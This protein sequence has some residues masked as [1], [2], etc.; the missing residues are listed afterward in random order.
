MF[1]LPKHFSRVLNKLLF[2]KNLSKIAQKCGTDKLEHG[3]I[4]HYKQY[5]ENLRHKE[6][7]I[8][9][10]GI[11]Q[12]A[13]L[14]MWKE[15]FPHSIIHAIDIR[16]KSNYESDRIRVYQGDQNDSEF[17]KRIAKEAGRFDII[18][19]DGSHVSKHI[20]TSF[21]TLFPF[22][23]P[24]GIYVIEDL[25]TAYWTA[26]GGEW[27]NLNSGHTSM[28]FIKN[29][30]DGL[31]CHWIPG[32]ESTDFDKQICAIHSYPKIVFIFKG[33]NPLKHR[34]YELKMMQMSLDS[35]E[36]QNN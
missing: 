29:L 11:A 1:L 13:S 8:L 33:E 31:N 34:P 14:C 24:N 36:K 4:D 18:I 27:H 32:H 23:K 15:Y 30:L 19:D 17:L 5:F 9:E 2:Q 26:Y 12:G 20:I 22:L 21:I 10:I 28:S 7:N 6:M 16:D 35:E 3:Y 25:Q